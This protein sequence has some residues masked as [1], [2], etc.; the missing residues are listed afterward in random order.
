MRAE[1]AMGNGERGGVHESY[2][3]LLLQ[4]PSWVEILKFKSQPSQIVWRLL[5]RVRR[6]P[7]VLTSNASKSH[8]TH[9]SSVKV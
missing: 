5:K 3:H 8:Q 4:P 6:K 7:V 2:D 9:F 1:I